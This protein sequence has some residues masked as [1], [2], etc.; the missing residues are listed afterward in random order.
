MLLQLH[1]NNVVAGELE[2]LVKWPWEQVSG[3]VLEQLVV[4]SQVE[5]LDHLQDLEEQLLVL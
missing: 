2:M 4:P 3:Q 5:L 1:H